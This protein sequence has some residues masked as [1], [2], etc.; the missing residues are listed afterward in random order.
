MT[1]YVID[2]K[3]RDKNFFHFTEKKNLQSILNDGLKPYIGS[4]AKYIEKNK[5]VFFVEGLDN[6]L[7]LFDC[8]INCWYFIPTF[9][10]IYKLGAYFLKQKWFP[11]VIADGYFGML[12]KSKLHRK[13]AFKIM[14]KILDN[15]VLLQLD[16]EENV[17]FKWDDHDEIK[18]WGY[19]KRHLELMGYSKKYS[20]L[21]TTKMDRWN[22]HTLKEKGVEREK[23]CLCILE[24][25]KDTLRNIFDFILANTSIDLEEVC[26]VL[27]EYLSYKKIPF[28]K[29]KKGLL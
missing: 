5:K 20:T 7:I 13:R 21:E 9:N 27:C 3:D 11:M 18:Q 16:L 24:N 17:D 6:L 23:I 22:M 2:E 25:G 19:K 12:K 1:K 14:D 15:S 29:E 10:F 8:W 4:H 28:S 26:P